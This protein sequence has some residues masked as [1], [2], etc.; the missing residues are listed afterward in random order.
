MLKCVTVEVESSCLY[1]HSWWKNVSLNGI[2]LSTAKRITDKI[3]VMVILQYFLIV[4]SLQPSLCLFLP[5]ID[6]QVHQRWIQSL[7]W[8]MVKLQLTMYFHCSFLPFKFKVFSSLPQSCRVP[9]IIRMDRWFLEERL[10]NCVSC[11]IGYSHFSFP[12]KKSQLCV[13]DT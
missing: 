3:T 4:L 13:D 12:P 5:K 11:S 10:M 2:R 1:M 8:K 7:Q 9:L 6:A